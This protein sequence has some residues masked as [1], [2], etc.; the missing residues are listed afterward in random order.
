MN[1]MLE[2]AKEPMRILVV[3][4]EESL[5]KI[6]SQVLTAPTKRI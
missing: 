2:E 4:D 1:R 6:L 3:D 5:R